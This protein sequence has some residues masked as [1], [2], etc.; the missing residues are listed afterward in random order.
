MFRESVGYMSPTQ[1]FLKVGEGNVQRGYR[2]RAEGRVGRPSTLR[3]SR[4]GLK[5]PGHLR[6]MSH[7]E[8]V[9]RV[10]SLLTFE[11]NSRDDP[12]E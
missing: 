8:R 5:W 9:V 1:H 2:S 12:Y 11:K 6:Q 7:G 4:I 10:H 3:A